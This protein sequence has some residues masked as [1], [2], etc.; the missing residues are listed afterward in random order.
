VPVRR[1][2]QIHQFGGFGD[3]GASAG[4]A[5]GIDRRIPAVRGVEHLDPPPPGKTRP[6]SATGARNL[7]VAPAESE[8]IKTFGAIRV[9]RVD[10]ND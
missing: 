9:V 7:W 6:C 2:G 3:P 8:R 1:F 5:A 4:G 10:V